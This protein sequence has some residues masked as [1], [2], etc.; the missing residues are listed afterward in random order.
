MSTE[1]PVDFI[2]IGAMRCATTWISRCIEEHPQL[3]IPAGHKEIHFFDRIRTSAQSLQRERLNYAKGLSWYQQFF[4]A[5]DPGQR[6]GE[7]TPNYFSDDEAPRLIHKHFP[8][9]KLILSL[10]D[11]IA[12][13][14]SHHRYVLRNHDDVPAT[15][16]E[17]FR[18]KNEE[19]QFLELGKYGEHFQKYLNYFQKDQIHLIR[20]EDIRERPE[21]VCRKLYTFLDVDNTFIPLT[22]TKR[23]N[24]SNKTKSQSLLHTMRFVKQSIKKANWARKTVDRLGGVRIGRWINQQNQSQ[25]KMSSSRLD[26]ETISYLKKYYFEDI[27]LLE[28]LT[29]ED[30]T[31]WKRI[32]D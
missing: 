13:L 19:Y 2:G 6:M 16:E 26:P 18:V 3:F 7:Y 9:V 30:L 4:E 24:T 28:K 11:P 12:R 17:A 32:D 25:D 14:R 21:E 8:Q 31:D 29:G 1:R 20:Y 23:V 27:R 15:L 22:L 5:A 10:R